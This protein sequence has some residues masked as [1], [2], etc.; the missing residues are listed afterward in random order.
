MSISNDTLW[1]VAQNAIRHLLEADVHYKSSKPQ[2]YASAL[3]SVVFSLEEGGK[4]FFLKTTGT[5]P[6]RHAIKQWPFL[7][8]LMFLTN[9]G[10]TLPWQSVLKGGL[11]PDAQLSDEQ[12]LDVTAHPEFAGIVRRLREGELS[13]VSERLDAFRAALTAKLERDGT[14]AF[15]S[16]FI[17]GHFH[18]LRMQ[19]TYV[20]VG[21]DGGIVP[22]S[23]AVM[24]SATEFLMPLAWLSLV[25]VIALFLPERIAEFKN[26][27]PESIPGDQ[28]LIPI[29]TF[30]NTLANAY[31]REK[32]T[33]DAAKQVA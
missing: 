8:G 15:W 18:D 4:L 3:A 13:D 23:A 20:D 33:R 5:S 30:F 29:A 27:I 25:F 7:S 32:A 9:L 24:K 10:K 16:P 22:T 12:R 11:A 21:S 17:R 31:R 19:A 14:N 1:A 6:I 2:R 26:A 28:V